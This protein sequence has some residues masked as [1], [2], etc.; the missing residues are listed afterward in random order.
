MGADLYSGNFDYKTADDLGARTTVFGLCAAKIK[1]ATPPPCSTAR[2]RRGQLPRGLHQAGSTVCRKS[3]SIVDRGESDQWKVP[4]HLGDR[5]VYADGRVDSSNIRLIKAVATLLGDC[6]GG[7][8][9]FALRLSRSPFYAGDPV[10]GS[11]LQIRPLKVAFFDHY[12]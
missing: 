2:I 4:T 9:A 6:L 12:L 10:L 3:R 5:P 11:L 1:T 8:A 7:D